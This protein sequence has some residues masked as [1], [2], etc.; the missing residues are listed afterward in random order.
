MENKPTKSLLEFQ[1]KA[2]RDLIDD[3]NKHIIVMNMGTGKG[4]TSV[5]WAKEKCKLTGL[6]KVL[7]VTTAS[8]SRCGDFE[9][10]ADAFCGKDFRENLTAFEV[11]SW[12]MLH[13]WVEQHRL[14]LREWVIIADEVAK[15]AGWTTRMGRTFLTITRVTNNWTGWTGTPGDVW[16]KFGAYFTACGK[17]KGK[18]DFVKNFCEIQTFKGFP[19]IVKYK[20]EHLLE[21]WWKEISYAPDTSEVTRELPATT[22]KI[23]HFSKP[24]GYDKVLKTRQKLCLGK[25]DEVSDEYADFLASPSATFHYLR[26]LCWTKEKE[27]WLIDF[28]ESEQTNCIIFYNYKATAEAIE[29]L[30]KKVLPKGSRVWRI[31]GSR[32][33]IPT[34]ETIGPRDVVL[35]QWQSGCEGL[36]LQYM[37]NFVSAELTYAY[38]TVRQARGR[39][40]RK[41]QT[42][43]CFYYYLQADNTVERDIMKCIANK[44][45]FAKST[46]LLSQKLIKDKSEYDEK[47]FRFI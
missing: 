16:I 21:K 36:N 43:P 13:K 10:E 39:I 47:E 20:N 25:E 9:S 32:H 33:E 3:P 41:G 27:Q 45:E 31:D 30:L 35:A 37:H 38:S 40:L 12:N 44:G 14:H 1:A 7:V 42:E 29:A 4:P 22:D 34:A 2:V 28:M 6:N 46:W 19:E 18:T 23:I 11:V 15:C 17:V 8:K 26:Q 24:R 5:S